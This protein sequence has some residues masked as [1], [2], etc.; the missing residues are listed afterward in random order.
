MPVS[1]TPFDFLTEN[2]IGSTKIDQVPGGYDHNYMLDSSQVCDTW[3]KVSDPS[4]L[5]ALNIWADAPGVQFYTGN[6]LHGIVGI[7]G[8]VCGKHSGLCLE[9]QGFPCSFY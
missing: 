1:G 2:R 6:F 4:S 8:A 5:R 9:T 7:R 3:Q